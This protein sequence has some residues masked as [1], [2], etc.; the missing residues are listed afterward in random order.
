M[1]YRNKYLLL[2]LLLDRRPVL[3]LKY[4]RRQRIREFKTKLIRN[5][6]PY[7]EEKLRRKFTRTCLYN[8]KCEGRIEFNTIQAEFTTVKVHIPSPKVGSKKDINTI[9]EI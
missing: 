9:K 6:P 8:D 5:K 4:E 2:K 1:Q 3:K 7:I